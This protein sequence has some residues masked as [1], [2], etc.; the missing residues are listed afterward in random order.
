MS[1]QPATMSPKASKPAPR[2]TVAQVG[3]AAHR[4]AT[5]MRWVRKTHLYS[6]LALVP[7]VLVYGISGF[8]FNHGGSSSTARELVVPDD[9][10]AQLAPAGDELGERLLTAMD[11]PAANLHTTLSGSWT[12]EFHDPDSDKNFRLSMPIDGTGAF[13]TERRARTSRTTNYPRETFAPEKERATAVAAAT[14]ASIGMQHEKLRAIGG[15]SLR[16]TSDETRWS[17]S[18]TRDRVSEST[19]GA[20]DF[21]RL[22]RRLHV[23]HGYGRSHWARVVWAVFVDIMSFAMVMWAITGIVMWWQKK[24][25]R[26]PG[27]I[28]LAVAFA[29]GTAL[30]LA[31]Q[32]VFSS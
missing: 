21:G 30:I 6:G 28:T 11:K 22:M 19:V 18:L 16:I 24:S 32:A 25:I 26:V 13:L 7:W 1:P 9:Q 12:F 4:K 27:G 29:G 31:L 20:F 14:L 3:R 10:V 2:P 15:P 5:V 23:T 8:L 17:T